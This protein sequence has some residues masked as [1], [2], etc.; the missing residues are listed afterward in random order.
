[1]LIGADLER[2]QAGFERVVPLGR[3]PH[4]PKKQR[5]TFLGYGYEGFPR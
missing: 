1:V 2:W 5:D 4:E 3:L